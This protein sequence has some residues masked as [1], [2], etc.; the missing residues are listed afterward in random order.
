MVRLDKLLSRFTLDASTHFLLGRRV[1]SL[2][3]E[4]NVF[5]DAFDE[6]Q[7]IQSVSVRAG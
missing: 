2:D 6:V 4:I 7:R 1:G 3:E 5:G